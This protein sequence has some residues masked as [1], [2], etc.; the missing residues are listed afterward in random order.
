[1]IKPVTEYSRFDSHDDGYYLEWLKE[2]RYPDGIKCPV[3]NR[4]TKHHKLTNYRCYACDNCGNRVYPA[5]GTIFHKSTT[6][7]STWFKVIDKISGSK[8][9]VSAKAIQREYGMTYKTAWRMVHKIREYLKDNKNLFSLRDIS[10]NGNGDDVSTENP[11]KHP[12]KERARNFSDGVHHS[13][14]PLFVDQPVMLASHKK[15]NQKN[16]FRKRDRTARLLKL[17]IILWQNPQGLK[18][19]EIS[20]KCMTSKRTVYRD[21]QAI[22]AELNI[23]IWEEGKKRGIVEGSFLPP[24]AFNLEEA[25]NI[26]LA[27]R[28]LQKQFRMHNPSLDSTLTKISA[29][30]PLHLRNKIQDSMEYLET[31]PLEKYKIRNLKLIVHAWQSQHR[32]KINY[33]EEFSSEVTEFIIEP[34]FMEPILSLH[35]IIV[36][37]NC[38]ARKIIHPYN[39]DRI[40][41]EVTVCADTYEIPVDYDPVDS[42]NSAWG[43]P[44]DDEIAIVKLHFKPNTSKTIMST[45]WH[46]SQ[47]MELQDDG[48]LIAT[49]KVRKMSDFRSW[50][51]SWGDAVEVLEPKAFREQLAEFGG[52]LLKTYLT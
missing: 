49:F 47:I 33:Q 25:F 45:I 40:I 35:S 50:V 44:T 32:I 22:E 18:V 36:I 11:Q 52:T 34:Y 31:Q 43:L 8:D 2:Q 26:F 29:I 48:S 30:I 21:L 51:L 39:I 4:I 23:P 13:G 1:M 41:G 19:E 7:L 5:A 46:P 17:L 42:I 38:P 16:Y 9:N 10:G 24:I 6:P 3:C 28:L 12:E 20:K 15:N 14:Q 37:A 27:S